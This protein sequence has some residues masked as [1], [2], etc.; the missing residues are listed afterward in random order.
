MDFVEVYSE[1]TVPSRTTFRS[2]PRYQFYPYLWPLDTIPSTI[3]ES[4][5]VYDGSIIVILLAPLIS[6][7]IAPDVSA[8]YQVL[9]N[10][11]EFTF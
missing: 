3:C 7:L 2:Q 10:P 9:N 1:R 8:E 5:I 6:K 11:I 4:Y